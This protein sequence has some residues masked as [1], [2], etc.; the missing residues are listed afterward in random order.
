MEVGKAGLG[1]RI[2]DREGALWEDSLGFYARSSILSGLQLVSLFR[3]APEGEAYF[4]LG[5]KAGPLN[6]RGRRY[7]NWN[8]DAFAY[9]ADTDP[10]YKTIP[11]FFGLLQGRGYGFFFDNPARSHFSFDYRRSGHLTIAAE[12][13]E[14]NGYFLY[15]PDLQDA[16]RRYALLTGRPELPPMWA[17]GFHQCRWS[18][19]PEARVRE[20]AQ[21]FRKR[22]IPCD[23]LY[24]DIDY[25]DGYRCFTVHPKHFPDLKKMVADLRED[26]FHTV[27]MI[28]PGLKVDP[29]YAP[30][31]EGLEQDFFC[32]RASGELM[33]GPVWPAKCAFPDFTREEVRR[34]WGGLYHRLYVED[35]VSGFWNDMN[36]PAVFKVERKTFP[37]DVLH[38]CDGRPT[39]HLHAHNIYGQQ[40]TRATTEGLK[41]LRPDKRPFLLTRATYA[42]GQR[43]ALVW[44]GDNIASWEHLAI[45]SR[46]MQRLSICGFSFAGSD[47]GGF[48]DK[49]SGE[50]F[51]RWLQLAV[52]HPFFRVHSM[53]NNVDGSAETDAEAVEA[54]ETLDR[55]DQEPWSFGED[56][57]RLARLAIEERYRLLP[58]IYT[59]FREYVTRGT[60]MLLSLPFL[61]PHDPELLRWE[62]NFLFGGALL[63]APV[64]RPG[65]RRKTVYLPRGTW[66]DYHS[67]EALEG[68]RKHLVRVRRESLPVFVR[69][70]TFLPEYPVRQHTAQPVEEL[71]LKVFFSGEKSQGCLYEDAGEG[72]G[73]REGQYLLRRFSLNP[74]ESGL[75]LR[76]TIEGD[77]APSY[78][79]CR[80]LLYG[81]QEPFE[82]LWE[83]QPLHWTRRG[84]A[85]E[86]VVPATWAEVRILQQERRPEGDS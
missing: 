38:G 36:E 68:G 42:G 31:R 70:G 19:F 33:V 23:A 14:W 18:Y 11:L 22:K 2:S 52:F 79:R 57:T 34:W 29:D 8:T 84:A 66:F 55:L 72:Y 1:L 35:G 48:V 77:Y 39:N 74:T 82:V 10:L 43:H 64:L 20:V 51:V 71:L 46:Q 86:M 16:A 3:Q 45:A 81:L 7:V 13:G 63:V 30:Y 59:A 85:L 37:D 83:G 41:R 69:A 58:F 73:Y 44:T 28:D 75:H 17:L 67:G 40:M 76:Q 25:M 6:L 56:S 53:G 61:D 80:L 65:Q 49:P 9:G 24:L 21:E 50:L 15:G 54:R 12:G 5:D 62:E 4:G 78:S 27:V 60:P 47:V 32:R 26:G